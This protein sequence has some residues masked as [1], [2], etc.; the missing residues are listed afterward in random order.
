MD[1]E[2]SVTTD[3]DPG[4]VGIEKGGCSTDERTLN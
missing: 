2:V 3:G 4:M 1:K